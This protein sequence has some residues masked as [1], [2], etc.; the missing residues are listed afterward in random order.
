[1]CIEIEKENS[2]VKFHVLSSPNTNPH[3]KKY[4]ILRRF[5]DPFD[6]E[7]QCLLLESEYQAFLFLKG[8]RGREEA[9]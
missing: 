9:K 4:N 3:L 2:P 6:D 8:D 7:Q 1:M 5:K